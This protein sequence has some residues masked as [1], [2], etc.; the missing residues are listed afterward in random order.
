MGCGQAG[1]RTRNPQLRRL[2]LYPLSYLS[3]TT[4]TG[5]QSLKS[6]AMK[7]KS[8][9]MDCGTGRIRTCMIGV[10]IE[11]PYP[12]IY[13]PISK[14]YIA[15]TNS[16]TIP[17]S[18]QSRHGAIG[19]TPDRL[20]DNTMKNTLS[21]LCAWAQRESNP[22]KPLRPVRP[23]KVGSFKIEIVKFVFIRFFRIIV[24]PV[25]RAIC[26]YRSAT[27]PEHNNSPYHSFLLSV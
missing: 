27:S 13:E 11:N 10:L 3:L 15:S 23:F 20:A 17:L 24:S 8:N 12:P 5:C 25:H 26:L 22:Y 1:N 18:P 4:F 19:I 21:T 9:T 7:N 6:N 16:A 2:P 14:V